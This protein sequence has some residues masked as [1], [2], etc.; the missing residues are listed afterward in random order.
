[1]PSRR[2]RGIFFDIDDTLYS[3]RDFARKARLNAVQAMRRHGVRLPADQLF[4]ELIEIVG[5]FS[6][7]Y[8]HHFDKLLLRIPA[9]A[10]AGINPALIVAA[11][12]AAYH[13]TKTES[14]K[15]FDDAEALLQALRRT[16]L[17]RG[18]I[19]DGLQIKQAEKL[20]RLGLAPLLTP[21]ALFISD[22]IGISKPNP[23]LFRR[24]CEATG[25]K[26]EETLSVG[27][28][29]VKDT[30]PA[31]RAGMITV[32]FTRVERERAA[33][34]REPAYTVSDYGALGEIL[35]KDFGIAL[36]G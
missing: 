18:V 12:V 4:D 11:A 5:E 31:D 35:R 2:L 29:P 3:T 13:D 16:D 23:K 9:S 33:G 36:D 19:T 25:L 15:P 34:A 22:Q 8:D 10:Y 24:A 27:D 21:T 17:I 7:N 20:V 32:L 30:D 14:L 28:D 26:P 1:M 6:S